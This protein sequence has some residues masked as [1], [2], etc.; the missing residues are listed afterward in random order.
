[1]KN[2][3]RYMLALLVMTAVTAC[4]DIDEPQEPEVDPPMVTAVPRTVLVYMV[5]DNSL[6]TDYGSD[7]ADFDEMLEGVRQPG[8]LNGGRLLVYY[9]RPGTANGKVPQLIEVTADGLKVLREYAD[10]PDI[11]SVDPERI[12]EVMSDMKKVAPADDYGLVMW[13]HA[14]GWCGPIKGTESKYRAFGEDRG[15]H[16]TI[17]TLAQ[18]LKDE[19]FSFIYF[20][21]CEMGNIE[22]LYELRGITPV[23]V[24]APTLL[25]IEGMPYDMNV[26]CMFEDTPNMVQ[27]AK[28]TVKFYDEDQ[29]GRYGNE[30]QI[31]VYDMTAID[32]IAEASK[33]IFA[34]L[35]R[36]DPNADMIQC[37]MKAAPLLSYDMENYMEYLTGLEHK[38]LM[39]AWTEAWTDFVMYGYATRTAIG[40]LVL[41]RYCGLG[42]MVV[43]KES[44]IDWRGYNELAWWKDVVSTAPVYQAWL[45][46]N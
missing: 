30:I 44:L 26:P 27:C 34:L 24:A 25:Q 11:Y 9:N 15:Y 32:K 20:D 37:Y 6:G 35:D 8:A 21:C 23:I 18:T 3:L 1:M 17:P 19:R 46:E 13:S 16:I 2:L 28:N 4:D 36:Y 5:A 29:K 40:R 22:C 10:D 12:K 14:N 31:A 33:N 39:E 43:N 38:D 7:Q 42:C 45:E 41:Y